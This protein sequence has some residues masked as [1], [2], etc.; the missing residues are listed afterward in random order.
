MNGEFAGLV[1]VML[2]VEVGLGNLGKLLYLKG[3][4]G[5]YSV[6]HIVYWFLCV[7]WF[8]GMCKPLRLVACPWKQEATEMCQN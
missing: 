1:L 6:V 3:N 4:G 2:R 8:A 7:T 5:C